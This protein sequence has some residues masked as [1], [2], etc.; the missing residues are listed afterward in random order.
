MRIALALLL[1]AL[2]AAADPLD[3]ALARADMTRRDLGF[4]P[5]EALE[6]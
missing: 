1:L 3:D 4:A 2:P 5:R 6:Q